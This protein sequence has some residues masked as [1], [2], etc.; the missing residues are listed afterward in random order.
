MPGWDEMDHT[1]GHSEETTTNDH[2]SAQQACAS[3][4]KQKRKCDK[5][6]PACSLCQ[7]IGRTCD[8]TIESPGSLPSTEEFA[9]LRQKVIDLESALSDRGHNLSSGFTRQDDTPAFS[10][11][12]WSS[13]SGSSNAA[14]ASVTYRSWPAPATFPPLFFLD[15]NAFTYER[16]QVQ[17]PYIKI[18]PGAIAP[19][20]DSIELRLMIEQYFATIH[21]TLP[22]ISKIRL[23][24][25]LSNPLHEPGAD[26]ALLF[27]AM[28][29]SISE[30]PENM[31]PQTQL[32][33]DVKSYYSFVE[34]QNGFTIQLIQALLLISL[35]E[36]GHG[37]YPAA[38]LSIGHAARLGQAL[39]IH[40]R[41]APQMLSR[42]STWSESEER[43]RV[44]WA[45]IILD[46]FINLG[47]RDK[48]FASSD[49]SLDA[50]LPSDDDHWDRG[51]MLVA[52]PLALSANKTVKA[53]GFAR[54]CQ[55]GHLLGKIIRN[56][57]DRN[58]PSDY[59]FNEAQQVYRAATAFGQILQEEVEAAT[60]P[61]V[62]AP[63]CTSIA[64]LDSGLLTLYDMYSCYEHHGLPD[65]GEAQLEMQK[66][67]IDG[68]RESALQVVKLAR[69][70]REE[71][72]TSGFG[73]LSPLFIDSVY[74]AAANC[75]F[76]SLS[77]LTVL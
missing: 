28:K 32:Y 10:N 41:Q 54:L 69:V 55:A 7:R 44:W 72:Q 23:H 71:I 67:A 42:P 34:A 8:Y 1:N 73:L 21:L 35:Y 20:G 66:L 31:P 50:H 64:M 14:Q 57:N 22:I 43:R 5:Q 2:N 65:G 77:L 37:I 74:Q 29:L 61:T 3:C 18:P 45:V 33:R 16:F 76:L 60:D 39:G 12:I 6:L 59:K 15:S 63:L 62:R 48:P 30:S 4:R 46:R 40:Q 53:A 25:H 56:I 49:P 36:L 26:M 38:Y 68:L 27:M 58:V 9:A 17:T 70:V 13:D 52:A 47:H 51:Q 11:D 24:Q 19:L 75:K